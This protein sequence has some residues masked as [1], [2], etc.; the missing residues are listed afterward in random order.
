M[1]NDAEL[2]QSA[3]LD[4]RSIVPWPL[5]RGLGERVV[6]EQLGV[7]FRVIERVVLPAQRANQEGAQQGANGMR[8]SK[9]VARLP[10]RVSSTPP[11]LRSPVLQ[12]T[13]S[14]YFA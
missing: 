7:V 3:Q 2:A 9:R 8:A 6:G 4:W 12:Q 14:K 5:L 10:W 1:R 11:L 13:F